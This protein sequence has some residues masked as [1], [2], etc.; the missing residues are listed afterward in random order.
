MPGCGRELWG[1]EAAEDLSIDELID[2]AYRGIRPAPGY[3]A[4]PDHTDKRDIFAA[5]GAE[6][7]ACMGIT[8][9]MAMTPAAAVAGFYFAHPDAAYF[10]VN[11]IG[12]DQVVDYAARK[13]WTLAEAERWL[14]PNLGYSPE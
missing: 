1:S 9:S 10:A 6:K 4:C 11:K 7:E 13:G 12:R 3:P 5:L 2:E 14:G 8:D